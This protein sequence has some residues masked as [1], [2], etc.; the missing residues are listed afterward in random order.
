MDMRESLENEWLCARLLA[1][2]GVPVAECEVR[3]FGST[4]ALIVT[5]FDRKLHSS[6]RHWLRLP[7]EDFCQATGTPG[8][9]KYEADGGPGILDI[10]RVLQVSESRDEDLATL[11][12]AQLLFWMLAAIDGHAKNFSI[13]LL[14]QGRFRLTPLYDVISAWPISG[15]RQNQI[16]A[17][18]LKLAMALRDKDKHYRVAEIRRRHFNATARACGVGRDMESILDEVVATTPGV[19]DAVA[20]GLPSGFPGELFECVTTRLR[21]AAEQIGRMPA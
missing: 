21:S 5:R 18:K 2:Y 1:A 12:R 7:Q 9:M 10:A 14:P 6:G 4:K 3:Q 17:K 19:I 15:S 20:A 16:H 8:A 13:R 11:M